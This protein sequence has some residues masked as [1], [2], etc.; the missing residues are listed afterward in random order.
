MAPSVCK[1]DGFPFLRSGNS[2]DAATL[3]IN[4]FTLHRTFSKIEKLSAFINLNG[5]HV[6]FPTAGC[7]ASDS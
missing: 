2:P 4:I 5:G 7:R 6:S 1:A 3:L